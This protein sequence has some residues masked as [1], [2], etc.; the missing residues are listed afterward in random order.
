[1]NTQITHV[2]LRF[3]CFKPGYNSY[4]WLTDFIQHESGTAY[5]I[6]D[7]FSVRVFAVLKHLHCFTSWKV[8]KWASAKTQNGFALKISKICLGKYHLDLQANMLSKFSLSLSCKW[9]G[10]TPIAQKTPIYLFSTFNNLKA[11]GGE[12]IKG[13]G[14]NLTKNVMQLKS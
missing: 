10:M 12:Y 13:D 14:W 1:M 5:E 7:Y 8:Y 2:F 3:L 11:S 9:Y 6:P 4:A